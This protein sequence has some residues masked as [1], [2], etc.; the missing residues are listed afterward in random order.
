MR[1]KERAIPSWR[2]PIIV[3]HRRCSTQRRTILCALMPLLAFASLLPKMMWPRPPPSRRRRRRAYWILAPPFPARHK[4][5]RR[6]SPASS[7]QQRHKD[8]EEMTGIGA[9]TANLAGT[10]NPPPTGLSVIW[11]IAD[12]MSALFVVAVG[13][14]V[15]LIV[16]LY[17]IDVTQTKHAVR[18]NYP[19]IGRFRYLFETL[20]E[21][22]RQ[23]FFAMD[24]EELPFNRAQRAW[25]YRAA[26]EV[27]TTVAFGSTR[28]LRPA[29]T[30]TFANCPFPP[31]Y[32]DA[33]ETAIIEIG[34]YTRKPYRTA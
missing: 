12:L 20:G 30:V 6:R 8:C 3:R 28:V 34:P 32:Q 27:D 25:V 2:L 15:A 4:W 1:Q 14:I 16:V 11:Q 10:S 33:T 29:G 13:C 7:G 23:Y 9:Q 18:R 19:V 26:K 31:L 22:F 17:I 24:R 5:Q 21:Y